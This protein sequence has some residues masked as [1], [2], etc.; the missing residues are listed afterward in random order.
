MSIIDKRLELADAQ[1]LTASGVSTN[2]IDFSSDRDVGPGC[3]LFV[4]IS[5]DVAADGTTGDETYVAALQT[6]DNEAFSSPSVV[7]S[8]T[9]P[10]SSA[11]GSYFAI[12]VPP[13]VGSNERYV[14]LSL[15]LGGTTPSLTY[16]AWISAEMPRA[17]QAYDAPFHL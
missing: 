10:R 3:P 16:S 5:L 17:W 11:A 7:A 2:V 14:R 9:I 8:V 13:V 4:H 15:T 1:A 12:V 6:D